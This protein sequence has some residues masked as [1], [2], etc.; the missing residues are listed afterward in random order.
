MSS[1][2]AFGDHLLRVL[3]EVCPTYRSAAWTAWNLLYFTLGLVQEEQRASTAMRPQL[4]DA[5]DEHRFPAL[6]A[7]LDDFR[8]LTTA[9]ASIL[10]SNRYSAQRRAPCK[11]LND[12]AIFIAPNTE[13]D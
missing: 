4:D 6:N 7:V 10:V 13:D 1:T 3:F 5:V 2:L 9:P 12:S 11:R 8:S